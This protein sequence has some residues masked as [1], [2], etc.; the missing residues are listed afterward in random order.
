LVDEERVVGGHGGRSDHGAKR[1]TV[2]RRG[3]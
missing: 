2:G 3:R 1:S